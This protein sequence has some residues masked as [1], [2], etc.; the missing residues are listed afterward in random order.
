ML[1][2][3][4]TMISLLGASLILIGLMF[5]LIPGPSLLFI[6]PGLIILSFEYAWAKLYVRKCM[7]VMTKS[8]RWLDQKTR[9]RA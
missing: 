1:L 5:I 4:K 3:R 6:V 8:A 9:R 7:K 2:I